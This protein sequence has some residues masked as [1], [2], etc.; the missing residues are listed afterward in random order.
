MFFILQNKSE[1]YHNNPRDAKEI[2]QMP[3]KSERY[4]LTILTILLLSGH[5]LEAVTI[6]NRKFQINHK[7]KKFVKSK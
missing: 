6:L 4:Q 5:H 7:M 2:R 3:N 1:R